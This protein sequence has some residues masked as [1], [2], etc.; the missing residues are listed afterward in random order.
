MFAFY[1]SPVC[2]RPGGIAFYSGI[3]TDLGSCPR[4][5]NSALNIRR[6]FKG[7]PEEFFLI[8]AVGT[9]VCAIHFCAFFAEAAGKGVHAI[10]LL[11]AGKQNDS[12]EHCD[13]CD[14][15]AH[16]A[17]HHAGNAR[18]GF[19]FAFLLTNFSILRHDSYFL[20]HDI[21]RQRQYVQL[22]AAKGQN[23]AVYH[24]VDRGLQIE[25]DLFGGMAL[26][27][28]MLDVSAVI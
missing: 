19:R 18:T 16:F 2:E 5:L 26:G 28:P 13:D 4:P 7:R 1:A 22:L 14:N 10:A 25:V 9:P 27:Q 12:S 20:Y 6:I 24:D 3:G 15:D 8:G 11:L 21:Q 23:F 17:Q